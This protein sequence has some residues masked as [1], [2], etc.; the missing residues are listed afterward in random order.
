MASEQ[1]KRPTPERIF[2]TLNAFH[3]SAA[4]KAGI[5]LDIFSAIAEGNTDV[6][7][8]AKK[9]SAAERGVRN[10]CNALT[11]MEFLTKQDGR[12]GLTQESAIFL[13]RKSPAYLGKMSKFL[14]SDRSVKNFAGLTEAV[15][16]GGTVSG[17][18]DIEQ[19]Q[20]D[21]W[22][23]FAK[24]MAALAAP[25]AAFIAQLT[26]AREGKACKVL[27]VAAGHGM[28]GITL[29]KQNPNA[30]I[31]ALDWP[32]V[33]RVASE[34]AR[35]AGLSDRFTTVEGSVFEADLG[36]DYDYILLTNILHHFGPPTCE[37]MLKRVH[38]ALKPDGKAITLDF[39]P[40]EDRVSPTV[41]AIFTLVM[42]ANTDHGDVYTFS[43]YQQM[44]KNAGFKRTTLHPIPDMP[45]QV[46]VSEK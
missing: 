24:S 45:Q 21:F 15:R 26:G 12:Y 25:S 20:D 28:Y 11:A 32:N 18:G 33:L 10:L 19:P 39:I 17:A 31:T 2:S 8:I 27:D 40:N 6:A 3:Q 35:A 34:N 44:F 13:D 41:P 43:E 46:L 16:K 5:E 29:A 1:A 22:V 7:S 37:K 4:L 42:L 23:E 9:S 14:L 38:A 30:Q 36:K